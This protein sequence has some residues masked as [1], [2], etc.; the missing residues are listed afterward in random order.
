MSGVNKLPQKGNKNNSINTINIVD[1]THL[2]M[3]DASHIEQGVTEN[4]NKNKV[5]VDSTKSN[6]GGSCTSIESFC[7]CFSATTNKAKLK[8]NICCIAQ[9]QQQSAKYVHKMKKWFYTEMQAGFDHWIAKNISAV[10]MNNKKLSAHSVLSTS[11]TS[12]EMYKRNMDG[13][14]KLPGGLFESSEQL[15]IFKHNFKIAM[16]GRSHWRQVLHIMTAKGIKEILTNFMLIDVANLVQARLNCTPEEK[17]VV[18]NMYIALWKSFV[19]PIKTAMQTYANDNKTDS[20]ALLY[21]LFHQYTDMSE[22]V[23][24]IYQLSLNNLLEKLTE[25]NFDVD[26]FRNYSAETLKTLR[27]AG[28]DDKQALLKLYEALVSSKVGAFNSDIRAYKAAVAAKKRPLT[29]PS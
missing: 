20:P 28:S 7:S 17:M 2:K 21:H 9:V 11:V 26:R 25:M 12:F 23:I 14:E 16:H 22:S 3:D 15:Q 27:N 1:R 4:K 10:N 24:R 29:S 6:V 8:E 19:Q 13:Q 18:K 5:K